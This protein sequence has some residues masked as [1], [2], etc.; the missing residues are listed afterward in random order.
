MGSR[1]GFVKGA[2]PACVDAGG[3]SELE[4]KPERGKGVIPLSR[5]VGWSRHTRGEVGVQ[6]SGSTCGSPTTTGGSTECGQT[7]PRGHPP[8]C[9]VTGV[10][11]RRRLVTV[12][13]RTPAPWSWKLLLGVLSDHI[14]L[15]SSGFFV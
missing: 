10:H 1:R 8:P 13:S 11:L 5:P 14:I 9:S 3:V 7:A 2:S 15:H 12:F 4:G 6:S